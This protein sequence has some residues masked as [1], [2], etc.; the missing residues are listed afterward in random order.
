[1][2]SLHEG[3][4]TELSYRTSRSSGS[5]GQHVNKVESRVEAVWNVSESKALTPEQ[6]AQILSRL[7]NR[8]DQSGNLSASSSTSRSQHQNKQLAT[9]RLLAL[10]ELALK[11]KKIRKK[12]GIPNS[13]KEKRLK[14]KKK[15]SELKSS[16]KF[17][18]DD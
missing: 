8:I 16:R 14:E 4:L 13:V 10:V 18:S 2:N 3:I 9:E 17:R 12:T 7:K 1:M 6:K 15:R 11:K 5:G